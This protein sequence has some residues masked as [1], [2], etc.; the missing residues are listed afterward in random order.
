MLLLQDKILRINSTLRIHFSQHSSPGF[1]LDASVL[2][3]KRI[4]PYSAPIS[5][6]NPYSCCIFRNRS[7]ERRW[8]QGQM[9][10]SAISLHKSSQFHSV[11]RSMNPAP[12]CDV[13]DLLYDPLYTIHHHVWSV[14]QAETRRFSRNYFFLGLGSSA[15]SIFGSIRATVLRESHYNLVLVDAAPRRAWTER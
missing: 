14:L 4:V 8:T 6:R 2:P 1:A 9:D 10:F 13:L 5:T 3:I 12:F 11:S 15:P 7:P